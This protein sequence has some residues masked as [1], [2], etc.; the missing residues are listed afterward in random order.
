MIGAIQVLTES[1]KPECIN[2]IK[3]RHRCL[4]SDKTRNG[5]ERRAASHHRRYH[6]SGLVPCPF[7]A[8]CFKQ[9]NPNRIGIAR[10]VLRSWKIAQK[11]IAHVKNNDRE[12]RK[13]FAKGN[14]NIAVKLNWCTDKKGPSQPPDI[15]GKVECGSRSDFFA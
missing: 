9:R 12:V 7:H 1:V 11:S 4:V 14:L 2:K 8:S 13:L 3:G 15:D 5:P 6:L 10:V